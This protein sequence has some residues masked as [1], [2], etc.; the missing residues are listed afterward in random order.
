[1]QVDGHAADGGSDY[2][3]LRDLE[4]LYD[5]HHRRA[6]ALA[7]RIVGSQAEAEDVIQEVFLA[8]WRLG[9]TY[10]AARGSVRSWLLTMVRHRAIDVLRGRGRRPRCVVLEDFHWVDYGDLAGQVARNVDGQVVRQATA[11][12]S[13]EQREVIEL[14]YF[15]G[16]SHSEIATQLALPLGTIKGR[17]RLG[18]DHLRTALGSPREGPVPRPATAALA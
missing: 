9:H 18:L 7:G 4:E 5:T 3:N 16:L 12:L 15:A 14:A 10:N 17:M 11:N 6:L 8:A 1:M 13:P 2:P